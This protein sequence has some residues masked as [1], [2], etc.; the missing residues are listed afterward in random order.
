MRNG[1]SEETE[2][3]EKESSRPPHL[4]L[5]VATGNNLHENL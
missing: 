2:L 3:V 5:E 1:T 4:E